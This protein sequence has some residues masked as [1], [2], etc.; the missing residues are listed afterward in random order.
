MHFSSLRYVLWHGFCR[1]FCVVHRF[2]IMEKSFEMQDNDKYLRLC[3]DFE[4]YK[5]N[6]NKKLSEQ[7]DNGKIALFVSLCEFIDD[8]IRFE[9]NGQNKLLYKKLMKVLN[10]N[11]FEMFGEVGDAFDGD[12]HDAVNVV[13][14]NF[15]ANN[16]IV[17][18]HQVGW[19]HRNKII[20]Y[21]KVVVNK[22]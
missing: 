8:M 12:K 21:A 3:A 1:V 20:R 2:D 14:N 16:I 4:N 9:N 22:I 7:E 18:V 11:G 19:K 6:T 5:R 15:F 10:E 13:T 17:G